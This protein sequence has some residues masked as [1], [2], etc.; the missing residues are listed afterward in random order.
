MQ[1]DTT[2]SPLLANTPT[3]MTPEERE[4]LKTELRRELAVSGGKARQASMSPDQR[5]AH[6]Q[7]ALSKRWAKHRIQKALLNARPEIPI[8]QSELHRPGSAKV[9]IIPASPK[10]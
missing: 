2:P 8:E 5:K 9:I 3:V 7:Y 4:A 6:A 1:D 10:K